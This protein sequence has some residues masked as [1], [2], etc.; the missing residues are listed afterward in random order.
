[1]VLKNDL[2]GERTRTEPMQIVQISIYIVQKIYYS[3]LDMHSNS[4][5]IT[6]LRTV[7]VTFVISNFF[8]MERQKEHLL[9][10]SA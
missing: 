3:D 5:V 9:Y 10:Q 1:M 2:I 4:L 7:C 6:E 8:K